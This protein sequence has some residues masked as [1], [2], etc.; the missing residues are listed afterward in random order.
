[1]SYPTSTMS[2][3]RSKNSPTGLESQADSSAFFASEAESKASPHVSWDGPK[4]PQNPQ[5]W[6]L[7]K[8]IYTTALWA[9][10]T[11]WI[12][13]AS[14]IYSAGAGQISEEFH[15]S[16]EVTNLGTALLIFGFAAGPMLYAPLSELYGRKWATLIVRIVHEIVLV[17]VRARVNESVQPYFISAAFAFGSATAKD[18][19]TLLITRFFAGVFG[20]SPIA[21]TGG[22]I[23]DIWPP[24]GT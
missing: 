22:A 7:S 15:V 21:I 8:Q 4:D 2:E 9:F 24:V 16:Y 14:A 18:I 12:T 11:C 10:T 19:Q 23:V 5:N 13:F 3:D 20:S 6:P 1:M 17:S